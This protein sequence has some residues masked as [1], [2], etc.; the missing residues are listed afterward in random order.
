MLEAPY[1]VDTFRFNP[2]NSDMLVAGCA[3]GQILLYDLSLAKQSAAKR[4]KASAN[5]AAADAG[6]KDETHKGIKHVMASTIENSHKRQV[7]DVKW[8]PADREIETKPKNAGHVLATPTTTDG[9]SQQLVSVAADGLILFWDLRVKKEDKNGG[10]LW[11]PVWRVQLSSPDGT[12]ELTGLYSCLRSKSNLPPPVVQAPKE[13]EEEEEEKEA[14]PPE[15]ES[16]K[17]EFTIGTEDGQV[18]HATWVLPEGENASYLLSSTNAHYGPLV[19]VQRSPFFEDCILT[20]GDW[21][22]S[23]FMST[24]AQVCRPVGGGGCLCAMHTHHDAC[25]LESVRV[26]ARASACVCG[27]VGGCGWVCACMLQEHRRGQ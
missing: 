10:I 5:G 19:A 4:E 15:D 9:V 20:V 25:R 18:V 1:D 21:S 23:I 3:S 12:G 24:A 7:T 2:N 26:W 16:W 22:F 14:P 8:L 11:T 17:S 13:G 6:S 27:W